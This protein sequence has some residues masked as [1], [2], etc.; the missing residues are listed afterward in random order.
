MDKLTLDRPAELVQEYLIRPIQDFFHT[1]AIGGI[2]LL[3]AA[4]TAM[5]LA[6]TDLA[7]VYH[8]LWEIRL[9][10]GIGEFSVDKT[11]HHWIN[12]G[13]M[14]LFFFLVGLEIKREFLVGELASIRKATLPIAAALGGMVMPALFYWLINGGREGQPGWGIP[15]ATD[16]AFALGALALLGGK[17]PAGLLVFL[18]ALAIVD[19]L[20][21]VLVIALFY[22][23][24]ISLAAL[25]SGSVILLISYLFNKTGVRRLLIYVILGIALWLAFLKS[26]VHATVAGVLMAFTIPANALLTEEQFVRRIQRLIEKFQGHGRV[27]NPLERAE[28]Q[29][30]VIQ[31]IE[32]AC[33]RVEAPLQRIEHGLHPWVIYIIM[34]I[35][36]LAN[37][38]VEIPF[39]A[40]GDALGQPVI[41]GI[42]AGLFLGK[43]S[44]IILFSWL[45]VRL[46]WADLPSEVTWRHLYGAS[47]LAGIGFTMSL[48]IAS[49][50]F[51]DPTLLAQAK[52]GILI[53]STLSGITGYFVL[54]AI[55]YPEEH[56]E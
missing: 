18:T 39:Y 54:R 33:R 17:V 15:M 55:P 32:M 24:E 11:L 35:F 9:R 23:E 14:A 12:D 45:S 36:G 49:L 20:G 48:F 28:D 10:I 47:L 22:G 30:V 21:A 46:G 31:E 25:V 3:A 6:N 38:G 56:Q 41:M 7:P 16:I 40:I 37:A 5:I 44:G 4:A 53:A 50:A 1:Q 52:V 29:Q 26:G 8:Q 2:L 51:P 27:D 19:D 42:V 43:Q 34:P 13:L